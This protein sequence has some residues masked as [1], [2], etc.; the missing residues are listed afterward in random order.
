VLAQNTLPTSYDSTKNNS[1]KTQSTDQHHQSDDLSP[2]LDLDLDLDLNYYGSYPNYWNNYANQP[3]VFHRTQYKGIHGLINKHFQRLCLKF[4]D[5]ALKNYWESSY[6]HPM[7]L[8]RR[9][10]EYNT[11]A[12]DYGNRWWENRVF[13]DYFPI[14]KGGARVDYITI[15]QTRELVELGPLSI[16]NAGKFAWSGWSFSVAATRLLADETPRRNIDGVRN[17][18]EDPRI[19]SVGISAPDE[20]LYYNS[21]WKVSTQFKVG[22]RWGEFNSN[23][24]S[25]TC[26]VRILGLA[27]FKR[28]PWIS[29]NIKVKASPFVENYMVTFTVALLAF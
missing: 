2:P 3:T 4:Y 12:S 28:K 24:S 15:G 11:H 9:V 6:L 13:Y 1:A 23:R 18:S 26:G 16:N 25:V 27:G 8:S 22:L 17:Y 19:Y 29:F 10:R 5:K 21:H 7:E 14:E 20:N